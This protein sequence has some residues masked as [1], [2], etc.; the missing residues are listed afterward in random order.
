MVQVSPEWSPAEARAALGDG[1][2]G[3]VYQ[4][5]DEDMAQLWEAAVVEIRALLER[6]WPPAA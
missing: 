2:F 4:R 3:G 5:P 6:D 1:S